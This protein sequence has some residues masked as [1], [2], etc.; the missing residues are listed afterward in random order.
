MPLRQLIV[1]N[2]PGEH[3]EEWERSILV[4]DAGVVYAPAELLGSAFH[5]WM[6]ACWDG[7]VPV[8][9]LDGHHFLPTWWL[10]KQDPEVA[11]VCALMEEKARDWVAWPVI[12]GGPG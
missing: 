8:A 6:S 3:H 5:A 2:P 10:A 1:D 11:P 9:N 7:D 4:D 12:E